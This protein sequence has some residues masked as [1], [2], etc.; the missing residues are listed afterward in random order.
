[1]IGCWKWLN[2]QVLGAWLGPERIKAINRQC[3]RQWL[4]LAVAV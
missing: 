1:M 2:I 3:D 4:A